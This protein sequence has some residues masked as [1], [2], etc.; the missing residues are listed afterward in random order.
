MHD[1]HLDNVQNT[2]IAIDSP[3]LYQKEICKTAYNL[4]VVRDMQHTSK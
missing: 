4:H 2:R 3:T 1:P